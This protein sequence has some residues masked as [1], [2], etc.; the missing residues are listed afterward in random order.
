M[1]EKELYAYI[2]EY[3]NETPYLEYKES[4]CW[5]EKN[6]R[7]EII[8]TIL[9][10]SNIRDGGV[11]V[12]GVKE[13]NTTAGKRYVR[14][15]MLEDH[16]ESFNEDRMRDAVRNYAEPFAT[17]DIVKKVCNNKKFVVVAVKEFDEVPV[18][19]KKTGTS[20][21]L[22]EG[23]IYIRPK[24]GVVSTRKIQTYP[25]M[26]EIIELAAFKQIRKYQQVIATTVNIRKRS[27]QQYDE[28]LG[29][30]LLD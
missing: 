5:E 16:Y 10:M 26:K 19:C 24:S 14:E 22:K 4:V 28:Q 3:E 2:F 30:D 23:Q 15:G 17:F 11:I 7:E 27:K 6:K 13:V 29:A 20:N 9:G 21:N 18:I 8:Q 1:I 25:E 12:I